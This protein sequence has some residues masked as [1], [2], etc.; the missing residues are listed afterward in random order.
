[1]NA[2]AAKQSL[3]TVIGKARIHLYKPIQVAE[4]LYRDRVA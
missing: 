4:I 1:M 2:R 3:D